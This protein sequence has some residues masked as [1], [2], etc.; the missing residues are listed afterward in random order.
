MLTRLAIKMAKPLGIKAALGWIR[1]VAEGEKGQRLKNAYWWLVGKKT[2][3]GLVLASVSAALGILSAYGM[4]DI[5]TSAVATLASVG[6][7][8]VE[9]GILDKGWRGYRPEALT[10]SALYRFLAQHPAEVASAFGAAFAW[11]ANDC[12][13][14]GWCAAIL[15][16][17]GLLAGA[18]M[19]LGLLDA[20]WKAPAPVR[21]RYYRSR[22]VAWPPE[23]I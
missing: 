12:T 20:A 13:F 17:L 19:Q 5:P 3:A 16:V 10:Q 4:V 23:R 7:F 11:Q 21:E 15:V 2:A 8:L 1:K 14:G 9:A 6:G 22:G 18:A